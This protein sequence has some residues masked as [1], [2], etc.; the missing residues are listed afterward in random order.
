MTSPKQPCWACSTKAHL[1]KTYIIPLEM[2]GTDD[3]DNIVHLCDLCHTFIERRKI[4]DSDNPD[5]FLEKIDRDVMDDPTWA[6]LL[7]L[8][9]IRNAMFMAKVHERIGE[10]DKMRKKYA[11]NK[12]I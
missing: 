6:K 4:K 12:K 7:Q 9:A 1:N 8:E 11:R 10:T 5:P 2:D 3:P